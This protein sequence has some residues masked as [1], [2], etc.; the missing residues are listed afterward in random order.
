MMNN[1][2]YDEA[3]KETKMSVKYSSCRACVCIGLRFSSSYLAIGE[4]VLL[5]KQSAAWQH[6]TLCTGTRRHC[7]DD[8][9]VHCLHDS[10]N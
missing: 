6:I 7:S 1:L 10:H 3:G 8:V 4:T 5:E 2:E 9:C